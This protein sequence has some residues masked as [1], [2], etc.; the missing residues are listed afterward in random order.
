MNL[1]IFAKKYKRELRQNPNLSPDRVNAFE[2]FSKD[3]K[4][5][6]RW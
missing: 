3:N 4:P 6:T 5:L 1:E 2:G